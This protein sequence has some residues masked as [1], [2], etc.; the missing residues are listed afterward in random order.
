M[1][2]RLGF[3]QQSRCFFSL[4]T[5]IASAASLNQTKTKCSYIDR[6]HPHRIDFLFEKSGNMP[7]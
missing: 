2:V 4:T 3:I 5:I 1:L 6:T 7:P